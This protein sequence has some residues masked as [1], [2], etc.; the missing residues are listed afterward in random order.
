MACFVSENAM[1]I[2]AL[3]TGSNSLKFDV[4]Q[5]EAG[6]RTPT[7]GIRVAS[8]SVEDIDSYTQAAEHALEAAGV[9]PELVVHRVVHG[10]DEFRTPVRIDAPVVTVIERWEEAAPLHNAPALGV[11]RCVQERLEGVPGV[12]VFDTAFHCGIPQ[13]A[14]TYG[15]PL[16]FSNELHIR[17]YGFHGI[18]HHYQ[19]LRY[20][21]LN[22]IQVE[23][24]KLVTLHLESG[25]SAAAIE[26]G[27]SVDTS[28]GFTPLEGLV[29]GSRCGDLDPAIL[30][31]IA[32]KRGMS[33]DQV[34]H[35][36]NHESGLLG[37]SGM[38][39]DTRVLVQHLGEERIRLALDV[40]SY[41]IRKYV[42]AYLPQIRRP[43][44]QW[45]LRTADGSGIYRG[46]NSGR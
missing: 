5:A 2:L 21:E 10:G 44:A 27:R 17:R 11:I 37:L 45:P 38:T 14:F 18:S 32:R 8:G 35:L 31:Y 36:L 23:K 43:W 6:Q 12:A 29:M 19:L 42:G 1:L 40:F 33:L 24:A 39:N 15:L 30:P 41:R 7:A 9:R 28:M 34:G 20:A 46:R 16:E 13:P 26:N 22:E 3:N 25:S 4:I